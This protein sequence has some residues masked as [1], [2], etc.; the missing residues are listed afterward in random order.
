MLSAAS[1]AA[2][3]AAGRFRIMAEALSPPRN[4]SSAAAAGR[5]RVHRSGASAAPAATDAALPLALLHPL[6]ALSLSASTQKHRSHQEA[7]DN[8][9]VDAASRAISGQATSG[10]SMR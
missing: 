6:L 2:R 9:S 5:L 4:A 8:H 1:P 3:A 7:A 10:V